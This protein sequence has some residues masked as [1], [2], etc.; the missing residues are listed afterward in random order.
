MFCFDVLS[1]D[2]DTTEVSNLYFM[3]KLPLNVGSKH[4]CSKTLEE[5]CYV[6]D[7]LMYVIRAPLNPTNNLW[8]LD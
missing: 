2:V 1:E 7:P 5:Y 3:L 6:S 4:M 8:V